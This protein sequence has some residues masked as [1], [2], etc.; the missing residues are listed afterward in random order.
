MITNRP[1]IILLITMLNWAS[2]RAQGWIDITP[3]GLYPIRYFNSFDFHDGT[4]EVFVWNSEREATRGYRLNTSMQWDSIPAYHSNWCGPPSE[5]AT[6][7]LT[8]IGRSYLD[9]R[10]AFSIFIR[11]GCIIECFTHVYADTTGEVPT[12]NEVA[13]FDDFLC[14]GY[15]A[16]VAVSPLDQHLA[17]LSFFDS[18]YF[19]SDGGQTFSGLSSPVP[20]PFDPILHGLALSPWDPGH[21][22][23]FGFENLRNTYSLYESTDTG[24]T[25]TPVLDGDVN[26]L[27]FDSSD[28]STIYAVTDTAIFKSVDG[29]RTWFLAI[30]GAFRS[31]EIEKDEPG[32]V[33]AGRS[34]GKLFWSIDDAETWSIYND[35]FTTLPIIGLHHISGGD[36][37]IVVST[38]GVFKVY[39][40]FVL[41]IGNETPPI[42]PVYSLF[43][44]YPNPFNPTTTFVFTIPARPQGGGHSPLVALKIYDLLGQEVATIVN[45]RLEPGRYTRR[46]DATGLSSGVYH[47]GF[48]SGEFVQTKKLVLVR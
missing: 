42:P 5:H 40:S 30:E 45:E 43:Q 16:V 34:D 14:A 47:Y 27:E 48:K 6:Y 32:V 13:F 31:I 28:P 2:A 4:F 11:G 3:E 24:L 26:Q 41:D 9:Q 22:F 29:G 23:V 39:D 35:T 20:D 12:Q 38:V 1:A 8:S 44:N 15:S 10:R 36:T 37:V 18:L 17:F 7:Q 46:W 25:W 19:S 21:L 33:Y